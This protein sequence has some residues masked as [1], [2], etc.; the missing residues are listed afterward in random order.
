MAYLKL[1]ERNASIILVVRA[2]L[3]L[4]WPY[5]FVI[6]FL[7]VLRLK[8]RIGLNHFFSLS[9]LNKQPLVT[10]FPFRCFYKPVFHA[11]PLCKIICLRLH[12]SA[13]VIFIDKNTTCLSRKGAPISNFNA[14]LI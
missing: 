7:P 12:S 4:S 5:S 8:C 3:S 6:I 2:G 11:C 10:S 13:E 14:P 9:Y 1:A